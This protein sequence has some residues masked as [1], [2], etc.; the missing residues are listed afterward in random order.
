MRP[1]VWHIVIGSND[2]TVNPAAERMLAVAAGSH[3]VGGV[4]AHVDPD[5]A[6][7]AINHLQPH[8]SAPPVGQLFEL[9][10]AGLLDL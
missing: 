3:Q 4:V 6:R 9:H 8:L 2:R 1:H 7:H 10:A 5:A